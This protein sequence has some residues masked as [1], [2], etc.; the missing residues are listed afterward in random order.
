M[1]RESQA[2]PAKAYITEAVRKEQAEERG[3]QA[4]IEDVKR[5]ALADLRHR[6]KLAM[7]WG[8]TE[9]EAR[10]AILDGIEAWSDEEK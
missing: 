4:A 9:Q 5:F 7:T 3:K 10:A 6:L 2:D 1:K 8:F